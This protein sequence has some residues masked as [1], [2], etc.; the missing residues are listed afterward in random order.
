MKSILAYDKFVSRVNALDSSRGVNPEHRQFVLIFNEQL[1]VWVK[2]AQEEGDATQ[3]IENMD[4]L[5]EPY[6]SLNKLPDN[7]AEFIGFKLPDNYFLR[8]G[9]RVSL[10]QDTCIRGVKVD[11]VKPKEL[12][13]KRKSSFHQTSFDFEYTMG[14]LATNGINVFKGTDCTI[15]DLLFS[16]YRMPKEIEIA[17]Y[18]K[19]DGEV[20]QDIDSDLSDHIMEEVIQM[21]ADEFYKRNGDQ[22]KV[23]LSRK[24]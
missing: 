17:G 14:F 7:N 6:R 1:K 5:L 13:T 15:E 16:Y 10:K 4:E 22:N 21:A 11:F 12:E 20:S 18:T 3:D 9:A 8:I 2:Q 23:A 24:P 19:E